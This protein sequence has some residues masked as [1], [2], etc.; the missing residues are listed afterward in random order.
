MMISKIIAELRRFSGETP[1][2]LKHNH[3]EG[4][5]GDL[6]SYRGYYAELA[7]DTGYTK[8]DVTQVIKSL[9]GSVG[10]TY[11]GYKGGEYTM[12]GHTDLYWAEYGSLGP[13]A[14][15][16][17]KSYGEVYIEFGEG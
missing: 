4:D 14:A 15:K 12:A 8:V 11:T 1:V 3:V 5:W 9:K 13:K 10:K 6:D 17:Y 2:R 7:V 16:V